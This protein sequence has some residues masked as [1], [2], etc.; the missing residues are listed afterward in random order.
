[1]PSNWFW[2]VH[3]ALVFMNSLRLKFY[4][5]CKCVNHA[6]DVSMSRVTSISRWHLGV[7]VSQWEPSSDSGQPI[8]GGL[9][10]RKC[11]TWHRLRQENACL[12]QFKDLS[13]KLFLNSLLKYSMQNN[14]L[15]AVLQPVNK[16]GILTE[17]SGAD[18]Q[19][20][21]RK[22]GLSGGNIRGEIKFFGWEKKF[23]VKCHRLEVDYHNKNSAVWALWL[24]FVQVY[25]WLLRSFLFI[26]NVA[27]SSCWQG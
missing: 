26:F 1:M 25:N 13:I 27:T 16:P 5:M 18:I 21:S 8:R 20:L 12:T 7:W 11:D 24:P 22:P 14:V 19:P 6:P 2:T 3:F 15:D 23:L 10:I 17:N 9:R 4:Q